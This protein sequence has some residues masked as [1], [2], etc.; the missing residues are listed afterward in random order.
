MIY[1]EIGCKRALQALRNRRADRAV[2]V[3]GRNRGGDDTLRGS[4]D[5]MFLLRLWAHDT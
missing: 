4:C 3:N 2:P 1:A 5:V